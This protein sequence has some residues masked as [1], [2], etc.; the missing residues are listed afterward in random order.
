MQVYV[1]IQMEYHVT[2]EPG[3]FSMC[4]V[5]WVYIL[6]KCLSLHLILNKILCQIIKTKVHCY[7]KD[8]LHIYI[9]MCVYK[10][11]DNSRYF[12]MVESEVMNKV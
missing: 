3:C 8:Q 11:C 1:Y 5:E 10:I 7:A 6:D 12:H 2:K 9:Y 4:P